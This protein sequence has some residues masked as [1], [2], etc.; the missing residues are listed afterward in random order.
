MAWAWRHT[1]AMVWL[2]AG[3]QENYSNTY[4]RNTGGICSQVL[5]TEGTIPHIC[6][7]L[8]KTKS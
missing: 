5:T 7:A 2:H 1:I 3:W 8:L 4:R 6:E